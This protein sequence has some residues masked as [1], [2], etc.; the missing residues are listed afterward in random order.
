MTDAQKTRS[1]AQLAIL[2]KAREKAQIVRKENAELRK[3]EEE[4]EKAEK[5]QAKDER[6]KNDCARHF[7]K[8]SCIKRAGD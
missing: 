4:I 5:D 6:K 1:E 8:A 2:A 7:S 3:K